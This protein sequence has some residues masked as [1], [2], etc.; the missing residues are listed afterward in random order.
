M[1]PYL[2]PHG[3]IFK[4]NRQPLTEISDTMVQQDTGFWQSRV[5]R[6]IGDWLD[7]GTSV[8]VV[9]AFGEKVFLQHDLDGFTGDA[10]FVQS[11]YAARM[12][13]KFRASIAG[14]YAWR[15]QKAS[16]AGEKER[17][18]KA[19]DFAFRQAVALCPYSPEGS[20]AA[21]LEF[22]KEQHRGADAKQVQDMIDHFKSAANSAHASSKASIFQIRLALDSPADN[23][24]PMRVVAPTGRLGETLYVDKAVLLDRSAL[25]SAQES[26]SPQGYEEIEVT[27]TDPGRDQFAE[28][29]REHIHQR[30]AIIIDGKLWMAPVVQTEISGGK[31]QIAGSFS[32]DDATAL[33][34]KINE[35]AGK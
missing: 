23:S 22:L 7:G 6:M 19:A 14:L 3:L 12:F 33:T 26:K 35:A 32:E 16:D 9:T 29:T 13:S 8:S 21:Y 25:Q 2:E 30:L 24:E 18:A 28:I 20:A 5:T 27:L 15:A 17:M 4:V 31:L 10:R 1:Y 11:D 34:A